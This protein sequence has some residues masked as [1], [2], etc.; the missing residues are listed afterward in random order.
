MAEHDPRLRCL[1]W[2][3]QMAVPND[4]APPRRLGVIRAVEAF[5]RART[6]RALR[7]AQHVKHGSEVALA[8][9][10]HKSAVIFMRRC[11]FH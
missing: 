3:Q 9:G 8:E 7:E 10:S 2:V 1:D 6:A 5:N 4:S 11:I